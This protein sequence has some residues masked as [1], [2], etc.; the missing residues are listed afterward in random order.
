MHPILAAT[1][2]PGCAGTL[3]PVLE[4]LAKDPDIALTT[5]GYKA[6][7]QV[8]AERRIPFR[9]LADFGLSNASLASM[10]RLVAVVQPDL[11]LT[12]SSYPNAEEP[13]VIDQTL[14]AAAKE[15][16][17][18]TL[19][20]LEY[21]GKYREKFSNRLDATGTLTLPNKIAVD[22]LAYEDMRKE[23][24]PDDVLVVTGNPYY[25]GHAALK[26]GFTEAGRVQVRRDLGIPPG[27]FFL[28]YT[29]QPIKADEGGRLGFTEKDVLR[30]LLDALD[31]LVSK[32]SVALVVKVHKREHLERVRA[33][34]G[35]H[36]FPIRVDQDYP[37]MRALL[38]CDALV[39]SYSMTLMEACYFDK[40]ALSLQPG[41]AGPELAATNRLGLTQGIY[42]A[43]AI[44]PALESLCGDARF[45]A[46]LA[47]RRRALV[48]D[49][50]ATDRVVAV[51]RALLKPAARKT[52]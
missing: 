35:P 1:W 22:A 32:V 19:A 51:V 38:A 46:E 34:I 36:P 37:T 10:R 28:L 7:A 43:A 24:F 39:A 50:A 33:N 31:A 6:S 26:A 5:V 12:G 52:I 13:V 17:V 4:R 47:A 44:G 2:F 16:G 42:E 8:F 18:P 41:L 14:R 27:A 23:G 25:D 9:V 48:A 49:G 15:A 20:I 45:G 21:P 30:N 29:S 11:V 40:P 3:A